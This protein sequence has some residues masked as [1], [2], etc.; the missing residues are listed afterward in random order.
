[1]TR[2]RTAVAIAT[3]AATAAGGTAMAAKPPKPPRSGLSI[4]ASTTQITYGGA[5]TLSGNLSG[6]GNAGV[7]VNLQQSPFPY[8]SFAS[9]VN[10]RTN[11]VGAYVFGSLRPGV[12][13]RYRV[14]AR[15]VT[16]A[17]LQVFVRYGV[18]LSVSDSTPKVGQR[19]RFSGV[20]R[21]AAS[22]RLLLLQR[23]GRDGVYR[24]VG[25]TT[26]QPRTT[27]SSKFSLSKRIFSSGVYRAHIN[28]DGAHQPG[29]SSSRSLR[30]HR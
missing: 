24:T 30:T 15:S 5:L 11:A 14:R 4:K 2:I 3:I 12:N 17:V 10:G 21:P 20:V 25:R 16:C 23:R 22:G 18:S 26:L 29:N 27:T 9:L 8:T 13:P 7:T 19:V 1:M 28:A 6:S